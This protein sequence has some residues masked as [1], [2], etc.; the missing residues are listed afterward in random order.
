M[1]NTVHGS[2]ARGPLFT[3]CH[4]QGGLGRNLTGCLREPLPFSG[5]C[6]I[7]GALSLCPSNYCYFPI[8]FKK[9][10][11]TLQKN[12]YRQKGAKIAIGWQL[13]LWFFRRLDP[14]FWSLQANKSLRMSRWMEGE[15][16][17]VIVLDTI[18]PPDKEFVGIVG[19]V[20]WECAFSFPH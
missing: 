18:L 7:R 5:L 1:E 15:E 19:R 17:N 8:F 12:K 20:V 10:T 2:L 4:L 9:I 6:C 3:P 16:H 13:Q 11:I 14:S